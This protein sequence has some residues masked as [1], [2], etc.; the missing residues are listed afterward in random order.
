MED[1]NGIVEQKSGR[2][3]GLRWSGKTLNFLRRFS[4]A[5]R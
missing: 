1:E 4:R 2:A 3:Q 5:E